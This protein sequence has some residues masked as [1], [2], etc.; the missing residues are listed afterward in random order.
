VAGK[1]TVGA[2]NVYSTVRSSMAATPVRFAAAMADEPAAPACWSGNMSTMVCAVNGVP[3][4]KVT[5]G[6]SVIVQTVKSSLD[7][8]LSARNGP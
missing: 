8:R 1:A 2:L 7:S 3:L 4:W 5:S 6:R